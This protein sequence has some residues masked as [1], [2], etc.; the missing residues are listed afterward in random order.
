MSLTSVFAKFSPYGCFV[1]GV[2]VIKI[3]LAKI[4]LFI[5]ISV[6]CSFQSIYMVLYFLHATF[7]SFGI[8]DQ[9]LVSNF[10]SAYCMMEHWPKDEVFY[11]SK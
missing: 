11:Y 8:L 5:L 7:C 10:Y 2:Y 9:D 6:I 1:K 4:S 3:E